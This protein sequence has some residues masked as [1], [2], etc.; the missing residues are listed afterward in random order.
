MATNESKA[1]TT[2]PNTNAV[3]KVDPVKDA[4]FS[5]DALKQMALALP[6]HLTADRMAR[7]ALTEFRK[8]PALTK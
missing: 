3:A 2:A 5:E 4:L 7:L 1:L 8:S 6:K